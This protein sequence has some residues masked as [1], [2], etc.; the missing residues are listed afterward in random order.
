MQKHLGVHLPGTSDHREDDGEAT[1]AGAGPEPCRPPQISCPKFSAPSISS[2]T[3][4]STQFQTCLHTDIIQ[5]ASK[6]ADACVLFQIFHLGYSL[7]S[8]IFKRAVGASNMP[9]RL[10]T[11]QIELIR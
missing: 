2:C 1:K 7:S 8:E 10:G 6:N 11:C 9:K 3:A 4:F 5:G